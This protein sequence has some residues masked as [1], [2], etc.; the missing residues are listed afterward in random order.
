[1]RALLIAAA[2]FFIFI[3]AMVWLGIIAGLTFSMP[4]LTNFFPGQ[5]MMTVIAMI[6]VLFSVGLPLLAI[7]LLI[8]RVV[9]GRRMGKGWSTAMIVFWFINVFSLASIGG[10]LAQEFMVEE[11]IEEQLSTESFSAETVSLSYYQ[12]ENRQNEHFM[13]FDE[14]VQLPGATGR[15]SIKKSP[16]SEW[17]LSK[18]VT[19]RGKRGADARALATE[20]PYPLQVSEGSLAIPQE[21]PFSELSKWRAQEVKMELQVPV[22][23]YLIIGEDVAD[24][25]NLSVD[26]YPE[27]TQL[28]QMNAEGRLICQDCPAGYS[29]GNSSDAAPVQQEAMPQYQDY[30]NITLIGPM[31]VTIEKGDTYD[32]RLTGEEQY[33]SEVVTTLEEGMLM[34]NLEATDLESPV[35]LYLT[36]PDLQALTL[37]HTDDVRVKDFSGEQLNITASGDFELKTTVDVQELMFTGNEGVAIEFTGNAQHLNANLNGGSRLDTDRGEVK[38]ASITAAEGSRVKLGQGVEVS[39][40]VISDDSSLR[41]VNK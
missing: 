26:K 20:L 4:L 12:L 38:T 15:F 37:N 19:A 18:Q 36:L 16:D 34:V 2:I 22:G 27:A 7:I 39:E 30:N 5:E 6:N 41:I 25:G 31:K 1:M 28:Y 10:T 11:H 13:V 40:Q 14:E 17:H 29:E 21:V 32:L 8:V 23:A 24:F 33:L 9:F 35:R 3:F